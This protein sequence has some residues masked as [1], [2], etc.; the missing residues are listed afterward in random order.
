M[1]PQDESE[2]DRRERTLKEANWQ[3]LAAPLFCLREIRELVT[4]EIQQSGD[5]ER[6]QKLMERILSLEAKHLKRCLRED[7][8]RTLNELRL[9]RLE[10]WQEVIDFLKLSGD[11]MTSIELAQLMPAAR[12]IV[13]KFRPDLE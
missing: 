1:A 5:S 13:E 12:R 11:M 4:F 8:I 2:G 6:E 7:P 9:D 10:S 3:K